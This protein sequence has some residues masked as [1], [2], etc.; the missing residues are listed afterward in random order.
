MYPLLPLS[1]KTIRPTSL[2]TYMLY[3]FEVFIIGK[4]GNGKSSLGNSI[5]GRKEFLV[6]RSMRSTTVH[7]GEA[8]GVVNGQQ[9]MVN[10]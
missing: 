8:V 5:L 6:A 1:I 9:I 7:L 10:W 2:L 4:T 3:S